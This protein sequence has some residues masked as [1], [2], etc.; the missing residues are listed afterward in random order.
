MYSVRIEKQACPKSIGMACKWT[1]TP[2]T[3]A[4]FFYSFLLQLPWPELFHSLYLACLFKICYFPGEYLP[5]ESSWSLA[6]EAEMSWVP[7]K[8]FLLWPG[9][10]ESQ[11]R[12]PGSLS[13]DAPAP[14]TQQQLGDGAQSRVQQGLGPRLS[15][16]N[17]AHHSP[18]YLVAPWHH[19]VSGVGKS[20]PYEPRGVQLFFEFPPNLSYFPAKFGSLNVKIRNNIENIICIPCKWSKT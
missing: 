11:P 3:C 20:K 13:L 1:S 5:V 17:P 2:K 9:R 14:C 16:D 10:E 4:P 8:H 6:V 12:P 7:A 15:L 18:W 19:Q